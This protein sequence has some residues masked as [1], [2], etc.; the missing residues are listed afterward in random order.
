MRDG[1]VPKELASAFRADDRRASSRFRRREAIDNDVFDPV[2]MVTGTAT[3]VVPVRRRLPGNLGQRLL[4]ALRM[5]GIRFVH[6]EARPGRVV[7]LSEYRISDDTS[8]PIPWVRRNEDRA[9]APG[10]MCSERV[11]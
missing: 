4:K 3:V 8:I 2:A 7:L 9:K 6:R 5:L 11:E 10:Q 1:G